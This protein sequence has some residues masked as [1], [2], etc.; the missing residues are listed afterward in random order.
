M[1]VVARCVVALDWAVFGRVG[2]VHWQLA[3]AMHFLG[4]KGGNWVDGDEQNH[5]F[6]GVLVIYIYIYIYMS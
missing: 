1:N 2:V 5:F 3:G 6:G 4:S